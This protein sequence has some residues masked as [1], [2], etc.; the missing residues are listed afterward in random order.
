MNYLNYSGSDSMFRTWNPNN[1]KEVY[2]RPF[3]QNGRYLGAMLLKNEKPNDGGFKIL[4]NPRV[5]TP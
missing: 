2:K 5:Y 3:K 1:V 4:I